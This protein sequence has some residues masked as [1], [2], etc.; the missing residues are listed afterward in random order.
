MVDLPGTRAGLGRRH[1]VGDHGVTGGHRWRTRISATTS[2]SLF[3]K[4][5][6]RMI[7]VV[8]GRDNL[9]GV[10]RYSDVMKGFEG[11]AR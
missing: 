4:Y 11:R 10:I 8:D 6:F 1:G 5:H 9:L 2:H 3:A 7:P